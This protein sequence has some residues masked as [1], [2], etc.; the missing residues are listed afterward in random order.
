MVYYFKYNSW[1]EYYSTIISITLISTRVQWLVWQVLA[2]CLP[3]SITLMAYCTEQATK[4][5][6]CLDLCYSSDLSL[7][8]DLSI[9]TAAG[10]NVMKAIL[11]WLPSQNLMLKTV[12]NQASTDCHLPWSKKHVRACVHASPI[13]TL[14]CTTMCTIY[15]VRCISFVVPVIKALCTIV[16]RNLQKVAC[17]SKAYYNVSDCATSIHNTTINNVIIIIM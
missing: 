3:P 11:N 12:R 15:T 2:T 16:H 8:T 13:C 9:H 6:G 10:I 14:I 4:L 7:D 17:F 5:P 1:L